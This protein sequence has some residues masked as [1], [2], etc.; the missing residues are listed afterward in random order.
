MTARDAFLRHLWETVIDS[1]LR[2]DAL[3]NIVVNCRRDPAGPF[4]EMGAAIE[5]L[6]AAGASRRDL[7]LI[8]RAATY[9]GVFG[10][11]YALAE[12]GLDEDDDPATL[13]EELLSSD[14]SG[15]EGR[16]QGR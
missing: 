4:G 11:L 5:R 13:Y 10:T 1:A 9:E 7:H 3:D 8:L 12:P 2:R 15:R 14:P 16:P 6:L